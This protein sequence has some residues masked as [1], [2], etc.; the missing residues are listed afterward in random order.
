M[1]D[2][3]FLDSGCS[4]HTCSNKNWF[5][6]LNEEFIQKVKLGNNTSMDVLGEGNVKLKV[7]GVA[8][9]VTEVFLCWS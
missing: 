3:L 5:H 7:N 2:V 9:V 8:H 1:K 6:D 4:N